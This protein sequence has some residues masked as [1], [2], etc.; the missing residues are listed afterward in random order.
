MAGGLWG[1]EGAAVPG[2]LHEALRGFHSIYNF[3]CLGAGEWELRVALDRVGVLRATDRR[4]V[5]P[6]TCP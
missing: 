5:C 2:A 4:L 6:S 3:N 1:L